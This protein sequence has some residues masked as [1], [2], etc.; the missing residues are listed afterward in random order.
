MVAFGFVFGFLLGI[1]VA[2]VDQLLRP[3]VAAADPRRGRRLGHQRA[4]ACG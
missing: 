1:P 3:V 4:R 2:V